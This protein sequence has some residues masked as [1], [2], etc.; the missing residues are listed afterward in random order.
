MTQK[1]K[2]DDLELKMEACASTLLDALSL[3]KDLFFEGAYECASLGD[4]LYES[5][6]SPLSNAI[7]QSIFRISFPE[8]FEAFTVSG[9]FESYIT[10]FQKIFGDDVEIEFTVPG[11]GKLQIEI[12]ATG[13]EESDFVARHIS[14]NTYVFDNVIYYDDDGE[15]NIEFQTIKG[16][17]TQY[18]LEQMLFELVPDGIYT[19]ITLNL[20]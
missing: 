18:E 11:P 5:E 7:I 6:R 16:F 10:V 3:Q 17:Q 12:T 1:F 14:N 20:G 9:S 8:I 4:V 15:G 13:L 2:G 19:E